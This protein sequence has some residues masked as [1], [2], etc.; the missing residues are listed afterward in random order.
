MKLVLVSIGLVLLA[1]FGSAEH[2]G[3]EIS[4]SDRLTR[5]VKKGNKK[6]NRKNKKIK[7]RKTKSSR[8]R[9]NLRHRKGRCY[10]HDGYFEYI[11]CKKLTCMKQYEWS[12]RR[13]AY[14]KKKYWVELP[15]YER[16]CVQKGKLYGD[17]E[18]IE[19]TSEMK[20][21]CR[22]EDGVP[23]I[24]EELKRSPPSVCSSDVRVIYE[25]GNDLH[26]PV[27]N[28]LTQSIESNFWRTKN[29]SKFI[30]DLGGT[31]ERHLVHLVNTHSGDQRDFSTERFRV[32][33]SDSPAG[34]WKEVVTDT[35]PDSRQLLD[36]L[37]LEAFSFPTTAA[38]YV[39]FELLSW[40]GNGGGL[41]YFNI[42]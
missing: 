38:R 28:V 21:I 6:I 30:L 37:P 18:I 9:T 33:L 42:L 41:Q 3:R 23:T 27:R 7:G 14:V 32:S 24:L 34:P 11:G 20:L 17:G 12:K 13:G 22:L 5:E 19:E 8:T 25:D 10:L 15:A 29:Q 31:C 2:G 1:F 4:L 36:P 16:C 40:Y 39:Q 35:L 26:F